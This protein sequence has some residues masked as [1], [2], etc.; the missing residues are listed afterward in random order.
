MTATLPL[1]D[2]DESQRRAVNGQKRVGRKNAA[3]V[4]KIQRAFLQHLRDIA[5]APGSLDSLRA[6][7]FELPKLSH[8]NAIGSAI[9][10]LSR[11]GMIECVG[12]A[13]GQRPRAHRA[14]IYLWRLTE[15]VPCE[16]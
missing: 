4:A 7:G 2:P 10:D 11:R 14:K 5:P 12:V 3:A 16:Q 8:A 9:G 6:S 13:R 1:F 15:W